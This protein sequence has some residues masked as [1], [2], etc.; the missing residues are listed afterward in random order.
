L[1]LHATYQLAI[2]N[3]AKPKHQDRDRS[4]QATQT[5]RG[6]WL[7]NSAQGEGQKQNQAMTRFD[8]RNCP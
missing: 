4:G 3:R 5:S 6:N 1:I 8:L 7:R 2:Q